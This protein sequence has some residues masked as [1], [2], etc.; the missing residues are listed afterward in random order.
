MAGMED[1]AMILWIV[2]AVAALG[3]ILA[4]YAVLF[5]REYDGQDTYEGEVSGWGS[6]REE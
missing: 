6:R 2:L 3:L 5:S 4:F 1:G